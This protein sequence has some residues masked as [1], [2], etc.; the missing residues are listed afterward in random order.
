M[1]EIRA[2]QPTPEE[3]AEAVKVLL[4]AR[5]ALPKGT[6]TPKALVVF[7]WLALWR[8]DEENEDEE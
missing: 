6:Y 8:P 5:K 7:R 4:D 1:R 2:E 3:F